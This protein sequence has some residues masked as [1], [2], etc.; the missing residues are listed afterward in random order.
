MSRYVLK[1]VARSLIE[2]ATFGTL[3]PLD[4]SCKG[5]HDDGPMPRWSPACIVNVIQLRNGNSLTR[6]T[7]HDVH[8]EPIIIRVATAALAKF[9]RGLSRE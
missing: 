7:S 8:V 3:Q 4:P 6:N 5:A 2:L 9:W 1:N